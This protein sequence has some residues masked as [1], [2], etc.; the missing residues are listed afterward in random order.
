MTPRAAPDTSGNDGRW[1]ALQRVELGLQRRDRL[2]PRIHHPSLPD[3]QRIARRNQPPPQPLRLLHVL[4]RLRH[5]V[6]RT[7]LLFLRSTF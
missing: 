3:R 1:R 5:L 7:L 6:E 2:R 4:Q